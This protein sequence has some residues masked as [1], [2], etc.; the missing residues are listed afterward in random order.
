MYLCVC[1]KVK[2]MQS[3][4][5]ASADINFSDPAGL[6]L[7]LSQASHTTANEVEVANPPANRLVFDHGAR[8]AFASLRGLLRGTP[9]ASTAFHNRSGFERPYCRLSKLSFVRLELSVRS[10]GALT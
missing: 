6:L 8:C 5:E 9:E 2:N 1:L 3:V 10:S 4:S 7:R